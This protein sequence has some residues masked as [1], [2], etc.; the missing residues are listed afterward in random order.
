MRSA[1]AFLLT[2]P[3]FACSGLRETAGPSDFVSQSAVS[4]LAPEP[5]P[6]GQFRNPLQVLTPT[7]SVVESCPDPSI[8]QGQTDGDKSW[9]LYCTNE[10][11][12]DHGYV[13][14]I[15]ISKSDD[16]VHWT[17]VGDVFA[18]MPSWVAS[19]GGL[20][21]PDIRFFNGKYYVYYSVSNTK[22][23]GAG[24]FVATS[25]KPTGPW[26]ASPT[27]VIE[28]G[29]APCCGSRMR[30]TI[31]SAIVEDGGQRYIFY[32]SFNGGISARLLSP[33]GMST[34]RDTQVQ[35][36]VPDRYE[37][38]YIV[39]RDGYFYLMVSA[40]DCC[41]GEL[42]GYG[43]FVGRSKDP[44][45]PYLDREGNSMLEARVGG[46]PVLMMN[47]N[48]WIG[49]GH[50]AVI[51]DASGQDWM[52]YHAVDANRPYFADSWT[53]RPVMLDPIDWVDGWPV[54]RN[55]AGASD[56]LLP[57]PAVN[58]AQTGL[59]QAG[60]SS[61]D[62]LGSELPDPSD[63]FDGSAIASRWTWLRQPTSSSFAVANGSLRLDTQAGEIYVG[64]HD[65]PVLMEDLP[66]SDC[67]VEV[68]LS[69]TEPITGEFNFVQGGLVIYK[70]DDNYIKLVTSS[71][72][73]T[74]QIEFAKQ[75]NSGPSSTTKYGSSFLPS[76]ADNT[77]LRLVKRAMN[78]GESYTAYSSHDGV[79]W[80][81]GPTWTH[82]LGT[83][84]KLGLV[85]MSG[86]GF[87]TFFDYVRVYTLAN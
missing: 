52:V 25:D 82:Q 29:P 71:I 69:M 4:S 38:S 7:G 18:Q 46:S 78:S 51:T 72:N 50:N 63:D 27:A 14:L 11:F 39:K 21:A 28:P 16:L 87:T 77:Y 22:S 45:G 9:Y 56:A 17:Y 60:A 79:N 64:H 30:A 62:V 66:Q 34:S 84:A 57:A 48:C 86:K 59:Y 37:A 85:S 36:T 23:G 81:K 32:G 3:L 10:R 83:G 53:R 61:V 80:R 74:R 43:V 20:W 54:V 75:Y 24:I 76:P 8:I 67:V 49:P 47:G 2:I 68:K 40:G 73:A 35:I 31:D 33:D 41:A 44:L 6:P 70:D 65:A 5:Y 13:H 15:P 58:A 12:A 42:S 1:L 26:S 55:G 19:N